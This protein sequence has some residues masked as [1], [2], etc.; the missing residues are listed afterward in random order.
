VIDLKAKITKVYDQQDAKG[1][2]DVPVKRQNLVL[3]DE[4]DSIY[5]QMEDCPEIQSG[6]VGQNIHL[7]CS[8]TKHG[9][10]GAI[11]NKWSKD[12]KENCNVKVTKT[13]LCQI[14]EIP[15]GEV[16]EEVPGEV[17][18]IVK[19]AVK[20]FAAPAVS[21]ENTV[22]APAETVF[23]VS[24]KDK[25]VRSKIWDTV[26]MTVYKELAGKESKEQIAAVTAFYAWNGVDFMNGKP[27]PT[28]ETADENDACEEI[29][30][31]E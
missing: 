8:N 22:Y 26:F 20:T 2:N 5:A 29:P 10:R 17:P 21:S 27:V 15:K 23:K 19:E 18:E 28:N 14:G 6:S 24:D 3:T 9:L 16:P 13:A 4:T 7:T 1:F 12:G 30:F 25:D 11:L 31:G